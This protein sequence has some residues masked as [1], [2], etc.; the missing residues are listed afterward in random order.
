VAH[1]VFLVVPSVIS[2]VVDMVPRRLLANH[3]L[4]SGSVPL[5]DFFDKIKTECVQ[6]RLTQRSIARRAGV[7]ILFQAAMSE[8]VVRV[9]VCCCVRC[10][11]AENG[12]LCRIIASRRAES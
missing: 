7:S 8:H 10:V 5:S 1:R 9:P 6:A 3:N 2:K 4:V 11:V 12:S